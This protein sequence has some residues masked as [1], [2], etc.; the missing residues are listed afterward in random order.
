SQL[1]GIKLD[2]STNPLT[3]K[4][5]WCAMTAGDDDIRRRSPISTTTDGHSDALVWFM[6][7][8]KLNAFDGETGAV[9]FAGGADDCGGIHRHTSP[10]A[11]G[12][13]I[14]GGGDGHL[15]AWSGGH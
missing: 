3:P 1:V 9:V 14:T 2:T 10:I 8:T 6:N 4:I 12:G 5:V 7:G 15:C 13:R 11:A